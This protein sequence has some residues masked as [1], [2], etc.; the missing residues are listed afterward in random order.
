MSALEELLGALE[1][2]GPGIPHFS[3]SFLE[4]MAVCPEQVRRE[5]IL[6]EYRAATPNLVFG[7]TAHRALELSFA[8]KIDT[9]QPIE[10]SLMSDVVAD[11][12]EYVKQKEIERS[13]IEWGTTKQDDVRAGVESALLGD[14][15][16]MDVLEPTVSPVAVERWLK[17]ENTPAGVPLIGRVD[18]ETATG[19]IIDIKTSGQRKT[20]ASLDSSVQATAYLWMRGQ[21]DEPASGFAWHVLVKNKNPTSQE[22]FT[23]RD[24]RQMRAFE[25]RVYMTMEFLD[26]LW[27]TRG[28]DNPWPG[29]S[30]TDFRCSPTQCSFW[31]SCRW[32][33]GA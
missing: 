2:D 31:S 15:G 4:S 7:S 10:R 32:R 25:D 5:K 14:G 21:L 30:E 12:F 22:L 9:G 23:T 6:K 33:G 13:G 16:Y 11:S 20:Q 28:P 29:A 17:V 27:E 26:Y 18:V 1:P 3:P 24:E 8:H 19:S